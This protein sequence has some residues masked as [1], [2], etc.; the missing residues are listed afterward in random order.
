MTYFLD[1][2]DAL[3]QIHFLGFHVRDVGLLQSSLARPN[4]TLYGE[5]AYPSL[6]LK[7]A[8]LMHSIVTSHPLIDGNKR[9]AWALMITFVLL[10]GFEV[11]AETDDAFDFVLGVATES[12]DLDSIASWIAAHRIPHSL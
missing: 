1:L 11:V 9:T 12:Q 6:D 4:T 7:A 8:A 3:E 10:N 2:D 5:D